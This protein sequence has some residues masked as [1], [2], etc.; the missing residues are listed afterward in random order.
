[1]H[2]TTAVAASHD[3]VITHASTIDMTTGR[4]LLEKEGGV[5]AVMEG[6]DMAKLQEL[7]RHAGML[8]VGRGEIFVV[9]NPFYTC[10]SRFRTLF[11]QR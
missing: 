10:E 3:L 7:A 1:M 2:A 5:A 9:G 4:S 11:P 6:A 8:D